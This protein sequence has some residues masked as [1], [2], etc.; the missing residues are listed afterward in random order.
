MTL[1][2]RNRKITQSNFF[3]Y[4][5]EAIIENHGISVDIVATQLKDIVCE[6]QVN[7]LILCK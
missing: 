7:M 1:V 3:F 5:V 4:S 2:K 6:I